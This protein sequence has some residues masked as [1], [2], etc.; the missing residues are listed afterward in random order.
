M[1]SEML[2]VVHSQLDDQASG[3][4]RRWFAHVSGVLEQTDYRVLVRVDPDGATPPRYAPTA[5]PLVEGSGFV[6]EQCRLYRLSCCRYSVVWDAKAWFDELL[7]RDGQRWLGD[8][9]VIYL[10]AAEM[11]LAAGLRP[12]WLGDGTAATGPT[13]GVGRGGCMVLNTGGN[14]E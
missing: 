1:P 5:A 10:L 14:M 6:R 9:A 12:P 13:T 3:T 7:P 11:R 2:S 4:T 8:L